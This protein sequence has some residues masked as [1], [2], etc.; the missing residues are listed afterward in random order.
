[1]EISNCDGISVLFIYWFFDKLNK[2][3]N[4]EKKCTNVDKIE[5]WI[6]MGHGEEGREGKLTWFFF[7]FLKKIWKF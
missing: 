7:L 2:V 5:Y 3:L 1:M 6:Y 4:F